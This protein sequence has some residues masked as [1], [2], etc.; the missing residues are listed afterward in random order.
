MGFQDRDYYREPPHSF[1]YGGTQKNQKSAVF[2]IIAVNVIIWLVNA[3]FFNAGN[4]DPS[5]TN[6]DLNDYMCIHSSDLY[7]PLQYYRFITSGFAH[8]SSNGW[9]IIGNMLTL[10]FFGPPVERRYGKKEFLIFYMSAIILSGIFWCIMTNLFP[11]VNIFGQTVDISAVGASGAVTAIVILFAFNYPHAQVLLMFIIPMPAWIL[12]ILLVSM[13]LFG[14][15]NGNTGIAHSA[16]LGGAAFAVLYYLLRSPVLRILGAQPS[17]IFTRHPRLRTY[18]SH[19][20][21]TSSAHFSSERSPSP[22]MSEQYSGY[23]QTPE[24]DAEFL[25]LK[26]Q[27][28]EILRKIRYSTMDSL[29]EEEKKTLTEASRIFAEHRRRRGY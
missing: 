28:D 10:F 22:N 7:N 21:N 14:A 25:A 29:S 17:G 13:D 5:T 11:V 20:Q 9:H 12:G 8:D 27:V 3:F 4:M 26:I 24:D 16:H 1:E 18:G 23:A 19:D 6:R 15:H 2:I